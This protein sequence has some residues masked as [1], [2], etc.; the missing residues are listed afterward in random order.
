MKWK[1]L[2]YTTYTCTASAANLNEWESNHSCSFTAVTKNYMCRI[3]S[4]VR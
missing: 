1:E 2:L 4:Q 3:T